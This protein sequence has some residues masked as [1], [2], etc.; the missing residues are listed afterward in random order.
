MDQTRIFDVTAR[1]IDENNESGVEL[2]DLG[3]NFKETWIILK[4]LW[5]ENW[6]DSGRASRILGLLEKIVYTD[7][8]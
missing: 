1:D 2:K 8:V 5:T 6:L 7:Y 4:M 3:F